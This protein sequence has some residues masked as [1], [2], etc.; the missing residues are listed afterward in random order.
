MPDVMAFI[1]TYAV[2]MLGITLGYHRTLA[3]KALILSPK[4]RLAFAIFGATAAQGPPSFWVAHH[5]AHHADPDGRRDP[6]SPRPAEASTRTYGK[7]RAFLHAHMGWMLKGGVRYDSRLSKDLREDKTVRIVDRNY[8]LI[9]ILGLAIP[10]LAILP[11]SPAFIAFCKSLYWSGLVRIGAGHQSTWLVNSICH[12]WGYRNFE[13]RDA[14]RNNFFVAVLT[15][16]E[17][18]HNNHH[19]NPARARHGIKPQ[20]LDPTYWVVCLLKLAG[21]ASNVRR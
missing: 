1:A 6:H 21:L 19:A 9:V 5:R 7:L 18:W 14:S 8:S 16:G 17:G 4:A 10:A 13:T 2:A 3:H 20:E 12:L 11:A 15:L